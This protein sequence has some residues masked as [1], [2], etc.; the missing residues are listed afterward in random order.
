[1]A[2][3][4]VAHPGRQHSYRLA[5][6]LKK[7]DD[8]FCYITTVYN[9]KKPSLLT[10]VASMILK[11]DGKK[12]LRYRSCKEL[13]DNDV[14]QF[15]E[16]RGFVET[17]LARHNKKLYA[18]YRQ[19]TA[20]KFGKKV[21]KFAIKN[22]V[23]AVICYDTNATACFE[24]LKKYAP[25]I[26]RILDCSA[27]AAPYVRFLYEKELLLSKDNSLKNENLRF[28]NK[29]SIVDG[30]KEIDI[31]NYF[32]VA[33][34]FVKRS[35]IY[36]GVDDTKIKIIPYGANIYSDI[37][38]KIEHKCLKFLFV[39][40]VNYNKGVPYL[41][42]A[43]SELRDCSLTVVGAYDK[44][45]EYIKSYLDDPKIT[46]VGCVTFDKVKYYYENADV[47]VIDSFAEGM[48]Q[49][50]IEAMAC[51][52]PIICS[53][54]SGVNDI[55]TDG[56]SGFVIPC[57][58]LEALKEKMQWFINNKN[59]VLQMGE[60]ARTTAENYTW[61]EYEKKVSVAVRDI[62]TTKNNIEEYSVDC[63]V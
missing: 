47:F 46:F 48:A 50:G 19:K 1:M 42:K 57:G 52:L 20:D 23:D 11:G 13:E 58:D 55:V 56:I 7:S 63:L 45:A 17:L 49:V 32:L 30:Q 61:G 37:I 9:K 53:E 6:S 34:N 25:N 41:L 10:M 43:V 36:S 62:M 4:V 5:T 54:N 60:S 8:L 35:L 38:K 51:G 31:S 2:K 22:K 27:A 28:W 21:A 29:N 24:V 26:V 12:R 39:G 18:K 40:N 59:K 15:C 16:S 3:I 33:S 44:N 14:I